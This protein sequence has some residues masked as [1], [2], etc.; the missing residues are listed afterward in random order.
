M[1]SE[2][3]LA[4]AAM[5][6]FAV[7]IGIGIMGASGIHAQSQLAVP[8]FESASIKSCEAFRRNTVQQDLSTGML[9][10]QCTTLERLIQQAYGLFANGHMNRL[11]SLAVSGGPAWTRSDFYEID[12]K[13]EGS[14]SRVMMNGPML[15]ALLED[16]FKL[17]IHRETREVPVYKLTVA[18]GGSKLQPFE[19]SCVPWDWDYP[20]AH[21]EP[22]GVQCATSSAVSNRI[23]MKAVTM[24]DIRMF[25]LVTLD[26]P[27]V[28]ETGM[29]GRFNL[30]LEMPTTD[31]GSRPRGVPALSN[32]AVPATDPSLVS[33]VKT[34]VQKLGLNLKPAE[35][36]GEFL[37]VD[38]VERP[39]T[40]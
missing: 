31:F 11:S 20:P 18:E 5:T 7:P 13:A 21:P 12:A 27:V 24:T 26:R 6:A 9:H 23:E 10:S 39:L 28:D 37:I 36:P 16:R 15:Q 33:A 25:F 29:T 30:H 32:P 17:K 8:K 1:I 22:P 38:G 40:N 3:K 19:G 2:L 14:Q 35:G 34:A 4:I